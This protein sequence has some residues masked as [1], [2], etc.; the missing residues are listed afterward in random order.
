MAKGD[1]TFLNRELKEGNLKPIYVVVGP[2]GHLA[3][4]ALHL[5]QEAAGSG[6]HGGMNITS[7]SAREARAEQVFT[8]LRTTP[9]LGGRPLVIVNEAEKMNRGMMQAM[10][11]YLESPAQGSTLVL[12]AAKLDGR[13][14]SMQLAAKKGTVVECKPL[15]EEKLPLWINMEVRKGGKGISQEAARFLAEMVGNDLGQL[16]QAVERV[17]LYIGERKT[18]ELADV[19]E[20][21]A[22]THQ[23]TIFDLTDAVG[24]RHLNRVLA[25]LHNVLDGGQ[26]PVL[27]LNMLARHFRILSKAKEVSGR[28]EDRGELAR[29][30]GVHPFYVKNYVQQARNFS[31]GE[32]K[33]SFML[34]HRCDRELKS[35]R[36]PKERILEKTLF[37]LIQRRGGEPVPRGRKHSGLEG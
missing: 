26:S 24:H 25:L 37:S 4:G 14:R 2:E 8:A 5:I 16:A 28:I 27:V 7:F 9:L 32:L 29:Y 31:S 3:R 34:L 20:A 30:L 36:V 18:I 17:I 21:V 15:Y 22:E 12:V 33:A 6:E 11:Q 19:E 35:S 10:E 13:T 1:I 23:R